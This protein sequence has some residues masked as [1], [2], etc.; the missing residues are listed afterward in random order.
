M[1]TKQKFQFVGK[2]LWFPAEKILVISDLHIGYEEAMNKEGIF[3]L[4]GQM[5]EIIKDLEEI[6][7]E[8][9]TE[10]LN[11]I[12]ILGDLKHE[13]G[14]I[15]EQEWRETRAVLDFLKMRCEKIVLVKGNHD[16]IFGRIS[17]LIDV[18]DY[19]VVGDV[20]FLHGHKNFLSG[21][22]K[23]K[24]FDSTQKSKISDEETKHIELKKIK[25]LIVGHRHPAV[26]ISDKYKKE[27][28][29]CF[30]VGKWKKKEVVILPS[31]FPLIE[32]SDMINYEGN[33]LLFIPESKLRDFD[34]Y[35]ISGLEV[36]KFGKLEKIERLDS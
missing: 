28:F 33:N 11:E 35:A 34:V 36:L 29:K 22:S 23:S 19:Y 4:R 15:S 20:C 1:K 16:T 30:L 6:F 2:S 24:D 31:F 9:G 21:T 8:I 25:F 14:T 12:I 5:E 26:M 3:V 17:E 27:R 10:K 7:F 13:F 18:R 32:G